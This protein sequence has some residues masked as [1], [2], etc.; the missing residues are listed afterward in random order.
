M[1]TMADRLALSVQASQDQQNKSVK[2]PET[3]FLL[4]FI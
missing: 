2:H 4:S 3:A 1:E